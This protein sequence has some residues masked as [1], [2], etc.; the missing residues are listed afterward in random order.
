M[1]ITWGFPKNET[2]NSGIENAKGIGI[3]ALGNIYIT[4]VKN[5]T[6]GDFG[7]TGTACMAAFNG[8][9]NSIQNFTWGGSAPYYSDAGTGIVV[10]NIGKIH[11]TGQYYS[12]ATM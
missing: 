12:T 9:G 6:V 8:A 3:D 4:G 1:N 10:D 11:I 2:T 7:T 5:G